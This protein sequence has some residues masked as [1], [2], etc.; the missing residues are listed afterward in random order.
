M[1]KLLVI[2]ACISAGNS[3][4][5]VLLDAFM[6]TRKGFETQ[7]IDLT[8]NAPPAFDEKMLLRRN[9]DIA[10]NAFEGEDYT[11][12]H[13]VKD[14]DVIVIAAPY[15]DLSFPAVVKA[16]IEHIMVTNLTFKYGE[17]GRPIGLCKAEKFIYLTT[18]G[19]YIMK[20]DFGF[21]YLEQI[22]KMLG[23]KSSQMISAEG[24]DIFGADIDGILSKACDQAAGVQ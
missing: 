16:F 15:W 4:T 7:I 23:V 20:P 12:A 1:K 13:T 18:A 21:E 22:F 14:A 8:K 10:Q 17:D 5:K 19:G 6:N 24:I 3:R 9:S 11:L 2:N